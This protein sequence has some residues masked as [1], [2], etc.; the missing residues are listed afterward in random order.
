[1]DYKAA[2]ERVLASEPPGL[3]RDVVARLKNLEFIREHIVKTEDPHQQLVN[4]DALIQHYRSGEPVWHENKVT[5]WSNGK[6]IC[7]GP[8][9]FDWDDV[10]KY[11]ELCG[12]VS[13]WVEGVRHPT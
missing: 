5:Y 3:S 4:V 10:D 9:D 8:V 6:P 13:F 1:M 2:E 11:N 7:E 12:G